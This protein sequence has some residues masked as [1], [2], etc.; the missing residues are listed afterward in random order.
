MKLSIFAIRDIKV[1]AFNRPFF[2]F[3]VIT[4]LRAVTVAVNTQ[5]SAM[6]HFPSDFELHQ[7]G[8]FDDITG[9]I[10]CFDQPKFIQSCQSLVGK[11]EPVGLNLKP[12]TPPS[13]PAPSTMDKK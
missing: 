13:V 12:A 1:S 5:D 11:M 8:E 6:H 2:E 10:H 4:A 7:I 3:S 9:K